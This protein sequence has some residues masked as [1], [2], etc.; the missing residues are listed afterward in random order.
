M[1]KKIDPV[2]AFVL[3]LLRSVWFYFGAIVVACVAYYWFQLPSWEE[4]NQSAIESLIE[5]IDQ[6]LTTDPLTAL[7]KWH[8]LERMIEGKKL[9]S[10]QLSKVIAKVG[11]KIDLLPAEVKEEFRAREEEKRAQWA[12]KEET[13]NE[14]K[15]Q[16]QIVEE[17]RRQEAELKRKYKNVDPA[18]LDALAALKK[19][20]AFTE[21]GVTKMKYSEALGESWGDIKVFVESSKAR[22]EYPELV[23]MLTEAIQLHRDASNSWDDKDQKDV[24]LK[25]RLASYK[26]AEI[27]NLLNQD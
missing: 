14:K 19:L 7:E 16:A 23:T 10:V 18:A 9:K 1:K 24:Q 13:E 3:K 5:Q 22:K 27:D 8:D 17:E 2:D 15:R 20:E 6:T 4:K 21:V 26:V 25:W 11:S 12:A